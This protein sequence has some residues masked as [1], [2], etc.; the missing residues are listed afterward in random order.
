M[1]NDSTEGPWVR[2]QTAARTTISGSDGHGVLAT[3]RMRKTKGGNYSEM[4]ANA[5]L[6]RS[7]PELLSTLQ[8]IEANLT[9]RDYFHERISDSLRLCR[10]AIA[11]AAD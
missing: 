3:V 11:R 4:L 8:A 9:G 5:R 6:I 2:R 10:E 1:A 7:A